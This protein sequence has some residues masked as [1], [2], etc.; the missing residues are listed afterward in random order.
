M[1]IIQTITHRT[2]LAGLNTGSSSAE[3]EHSMNELKELAKA[4]DLEVV[5]IYTQNLPNPIA[6]TYIG[7]GKI[8]EIR[9]GIANWE[10]D[11]IVF[12]E[13]LSPIQLRNLADALGI[14][15][16]DRTSLI[17]RIF[18]QRARTK[19]AMLQVELADLQY[20]LPRLAGLH[21]SLSRQGGG[22][23]SM[24]NKGA[25]ETQ[26]ELDRRHIEQRI[27]ELKRSLDAVAKEREVTRSGR[28]RS[29]IP[30]V[31]LVGYTN[32]G[33]S[34]VMNWM[35]DSFSDRS[36]K[37]VL[38]K[39]MLFATL[40]TTIRKIA[41]GN[42]NPPFL[43]S[44]T[45]GFISKLPHSLIKAFH[46]TLEEAAY[47][48]V[49]LQI[50][51]ASDEHHEDHVRVTT[52]TLRGLNASDIPCLYVYNKAEKIM[53][54]EKLPM[55]V[56]DKIYLSAKEHIGMDSLLQMIYQ[57]IFDNRKTCDFLLPLSRGD[58]LNT[59]FQNAVVLEYEY[60]E[61]GIFCSCICTEKEK[62][63]FE[64]YIVINAQDS[65]SLFSKTSL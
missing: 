22:S 45:V 46:S 38:E 28:N 49:I 10:V 15:I 14:T 48:D 59:L 30:R 56:N 13:A 7:G 34:T 19:E 24:S 57:K 27:S 62:S 44:D 39:D 21:T 11:T 23:G 35:I 65:Y 26:M 29:G 31:A 33:K 61:N 60:R 16:L 50:I 32:A 2:F 36:E 37:K 52:D 40:D 18:K 5:G 20:K 4:L 17:L 53:P 8:E 6:A 51:D 1:D 64:Q 43:L 58:I 3:F 55:I 63:R 47:A 25:G 12:D 54:A 41:P 9:E 42:G